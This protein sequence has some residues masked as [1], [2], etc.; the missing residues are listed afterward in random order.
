MPSP[1]LAPLVLSHAE[2]ASL[3]ALVRKRMA[4]QSLAQRA[5]IVLACAEDSG[6]VAVTAVAGQDTDRPPAGHCSGPQA[7]PPNGDRP[8]SRRPE[9]R[10]CALVTPVWRA[11][12]RSSC[13]HLRPGIAR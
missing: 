7:P 9:I 3:E 13:H 4:S 12:R 11:A 6:T 1:K 8:K 2:R 10:P 5:R